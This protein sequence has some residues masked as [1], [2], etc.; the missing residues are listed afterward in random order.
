MSFLYTRSPHLDLDL[1][2]E[3]SGVGAT[4]TVGWVPLAPGPRFS[5]S[6]SSTECSRQ[7]GPG[8]KKFGVFGSRGIDGCSWLS[9][10]SVRSLAFLCALGE[11]SPSC[12][13]PIQSFLPWLATPRCVP[14]PIGTDVV[15][16]GTVSCR[17]GLENHPLGWWSRC[18]T[19]LNSTFPWRR[20]TPCVLS[21]P[22]PLQPWLE[23]W[24]RWERELVV[25]W[26]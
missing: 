19:R 12:T 13:S 25:S 26:E 11:R 2:G 8:G 1:E 21:S 17:G 7:P 20:F 22:F 23:T 5:L 4:V 14:V 15:P 24:E 10:W 16:V 18:I 6:P 3:R 9:V